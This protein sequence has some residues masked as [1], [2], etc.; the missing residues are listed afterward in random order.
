MNDLFRPHL[1]KFVLAFFDDILVYSSNIND[2]LIHLKLVLEL[3]T[4][5]QFFAKYSKCVFVEP[6]IAYL[7][8]LISAQGVQPDPKKIKA[9]LEWP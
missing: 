6:T 8:H 2:H 7:G 5:N 1:R 4:T 3:L 9:I